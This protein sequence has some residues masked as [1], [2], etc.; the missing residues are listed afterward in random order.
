MLASTVIIPIEEMRISIDRNFL[1]LGFFMD[2]VYRGVVDGISG[3]VAKDIGEV[4]V[5]V[6]DAYESVAFCS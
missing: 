6:V 3:V 5:S 1:L 2:V 4:C